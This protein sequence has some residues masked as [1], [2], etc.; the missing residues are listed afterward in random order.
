MI[1]TNRVI[2]YLMG[3]NRG[4]GRLQENFI[5][6]ADKKTR[7]KVLESDMDFNLKCWKQLRF[8][9]TRDLEERLTDTIERF[10]GLS[11]SEKVG[12]HA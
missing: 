7:G 9:S 11:A 3:L 1:V 10:Y 8:E 5:L 12:E 6:I 4:K 2:S